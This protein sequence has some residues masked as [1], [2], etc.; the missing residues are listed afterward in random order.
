MPL[1]LVALLFGCTVSL[2]APTIALVEFPMLLLLGGP[3]AL[4]STRFALGGRRLAAIP[5]PA[6]P[7]PPPRQAA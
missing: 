7:P 5:L 1:T 6:G 3:L 2:T 4:L